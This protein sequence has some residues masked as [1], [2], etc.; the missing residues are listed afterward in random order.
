MGLILFI[1]FIS[2]PV[3]AQN[4]QLIY[5]QPPPSDFDI[6]VQ[7]FCNYS[8]KIVHE[9]P[10]CNVWGDQVNNQTGQSERVCLEHRHIRGN[11]VL[12]GIGLLFFGLFVWMV[13]TAGREE[14]PPQR[15]PQRRY[16]R[17]Y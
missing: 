2:T 1:V 11:V 12:W 16:Y 8:G 15:I 13:K 4:T 10:A 5:V 9:F 14:E 3:T 6:M 17:R 7:W